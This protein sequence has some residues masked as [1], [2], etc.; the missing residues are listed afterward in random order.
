M[1]LPASAMPVIELR[2][3]PPLDIVD[4]PYGFSLNRKL[5]SSYTGALFTVV[6][7]NTTN[8][9]SL[10]TLEIFPTSNGTYD[11]GALVSFL[12]GYNFGAILDVKNQGTDTTRRLVNTGSVQQPV[13]WDAVSNPSNPLST[14][15]GRLYCDFFSPDQ[16]S[17]ALVNSSNVLSRFTLGTDYTDFLVHGDVANTEQSVCWGDVTGV[18]SDANINPHRGGD[19]VGIVYDTS[20]PN[21]AFINRGTGYIQQELFTSVKTSTTKNIEVNNVAQTETTGTS[22]GGNTI[23][24]LGLCRVSSTNRYSNGWFFEDIFYNNVVVS[25]S[26]RNELNQNIQSFY[27][28][29]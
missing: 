20:T 29:V 15:N 13:I 14:F 10:G 1:I 2:Y 12:T 28:I 8:G 11:R 27:G 19:N 4:S 3:F 25:T 23:A 18:A 26:N 22:A 5:K 21:F 24:Y 7:K 17:L 6:R 9:A 16:R